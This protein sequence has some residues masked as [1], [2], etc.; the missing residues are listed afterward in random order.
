MNFYNNEKTKKIKVENASPRFYP[1]A[2]EE[3]KND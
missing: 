2:K 1:K 3:R